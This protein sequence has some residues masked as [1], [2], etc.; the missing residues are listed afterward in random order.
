MQEDFPAIIHEF[1]PR[2][3]AVGENIF[4]YK[5]PFERRDKHVTSLQ[6][7]PALY[8]LFPDFASA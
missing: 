2:L 8:Y 3:G 4:P 1:N 5:S 7:H 6:L